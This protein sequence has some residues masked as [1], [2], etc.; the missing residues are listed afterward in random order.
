MAN[1]PPGPRRRAPSGVQAAPRATAAATPSAATMTLVP[2]RAAR[3][4]TAPRPAARSACQ[5]T[6]PQA[7]ATWRE[8]MP[9]ATAYRMAAVTGLMT[10]A[11]RART[12]QPTPSRTRGPSMS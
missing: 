7:R 10:V 8:A 2:P 3:T 11:A 1:R 6:V 12:N 9:A 4:G 5:L